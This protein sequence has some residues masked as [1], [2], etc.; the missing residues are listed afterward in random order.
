MQ[1]LYEQSFG[2][3]L[4]RLV[5]LDEPVERSGVLFYSNRSRLQGPSRPLLFES[6]CVLSPMLPPFVRLFRISEACHDM[7]FE[8]GIFQRHTCTVSVSK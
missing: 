6:G 8:G 1:G 7:P 5:L 3:N 4:F 2:L